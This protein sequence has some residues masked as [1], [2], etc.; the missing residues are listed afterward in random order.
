MGAITK[1]VRKAIPL[2][3]P[4]QF[5]REV[6]EELTKKLGKDVP[7]TA[8]PTGEALDILQQAERNPDFQAFW[9]ITS[10]I[11]S[12]AK[13][14]HLPSQPMM[15]LKSELYKPP[16]LY[17]ADHPAET[18]SL[19]TGYSPFLER[20]LED[21]RNL[22]SEGMINPPAEAL[23]SD[24]AM[25]VVGDLPRGLA[26]VLH[27]KPKLFKAPENDLRQMMWKY[28]EESYP[29]LRNRLPRPQTLDRSFKNLK[30]IFSDEYP[31]V[32]NLAEA[33]NV[34]DEIMLDVLKSSESTGFHLTD[35]LIPKGADEYIL[36]DPSKTSVITGLE[37]TN[38]DLLKK[39][40]VILGTGLGATGLA[41]DEAEAFP[42]GKV[43]K[44]GTKKA[45]KIT[46]ETLESSATKALKD[47][48][49]HGKKIVKVTKAKSST[50]EK[51][52]MQPWKD[53]RYLHF[54][55]GSI[56]P[57]SVDYLNAYIRAAGT[58]KYK[59][60]F[61]KASPAKQLEMA[62][63]SLDTRLS[64]VGTGKVS[65]LQELIKNTRKMLEEIDPSLVE[66]GAWVRYPKGTKESWVK[67]MPKFYADLLA[68]KKIVT[69]LRPSR[70]PK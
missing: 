32:Q 5:L 47:V 25:S 20:R 27:Y 11:P 14:G 34:Y 19:E 12:L 52:R 44:A 46:K 51:K 41:P 69:K 58:K 50:A 18:Y 36:T 68:K 15:D 38:K 22:L 45:A 29:K 17:V 30:T 13:K 8:L 67:H 1:A 35:M 63:T 66:E 21:V 23:A 42:L 56:L 54:D 64:R 59:E 10:D 28:M 57:L 24:L 33:K 43:V 9:R 55:D 26:A 31:L 2:S 65:Q 40:A 37:V 3:E 39:L 49:L 70:L 4:L 7:P 16:G 62:K 6:A 53:W 60:K 61:L 48:E